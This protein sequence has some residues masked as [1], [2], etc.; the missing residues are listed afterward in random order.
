MILSFTNFAS[1]SGPFC[2]KYQDKLDEFVGF[3][4]INMFVNPQFKKYGKQKQYI[5]SKNVYYY[6]INEEIRF[7]ICKNTFRDE[8]NLI[9]LTKEIV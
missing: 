1:P 8:Y 6:D 7:D 5:K 2:V 9:K 4:Y 3:E